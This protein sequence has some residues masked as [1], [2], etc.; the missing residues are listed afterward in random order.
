[1]STTEESSPATDA[2]E[3]LFDA[4]ADAAA[5]QQQPQT[6]D[7]GVTEGDRIADE[8]F[9]VAAFEDAASKH[10]WEGTRGM[11]AWGAKGLIAIS[12][13]IKQCGFDLR[14]DYQY[15]ILRFDITQVHPEG[16]RVG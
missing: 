12:L 5:A 10:T 14:P 8:R 16:L 2:A 4:I 11:Q 9:V 3:D 7:E 13:P 6:I 1:M 15:P